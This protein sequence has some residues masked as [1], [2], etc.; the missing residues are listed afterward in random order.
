[1]QGI[2]ALQQASHMIKKITNRAELKTIRRCIRVKEIK[3]LGRKKK[4]YYINFIFQ[5]I[6]KMSKRRLAPRLDAATV[7][8]SGMKAVC[9]ILFAEFTAHQL[10]RTLADASLPSDVDA[11]LDD[12]DDVEPSRDLSDVFFF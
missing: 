9:K 10:D 7:Y 12:K 1:L 8:K 2:R 3:C 5:R 11:I 6:K 4:N